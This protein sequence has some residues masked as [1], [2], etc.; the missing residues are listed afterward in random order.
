MAL[1]LGMVLVGATPATG[2]A[3][4]AA[5]PPPVRAVDDPQPDPGR[6]AYIGD[7]PHRSVATIGTHGALTPLLPPG[8]AGNDCQASARGDDMVWVSDR[9]GTG[10]GLFRRTGDGPVTP[11]VQL[12]GGRLADPVLSPDRRLIAFVS[13]E[14]DDG[15]GS[16]TSADRCDDS[17]G[18]FGG[19]QP[20]VWVVRTDGTGL[21]EA[22]RNAD[23]ADWSPDGT[24]FVFT[25][26]E[27]A[28]RTTVAAGGA[29]VPVSYGETPAAKPVWEP[30]VPGGRNRIAYITRTGEDEQ[31][32]ATVPAAG[33]GETPADI[34]AV[35]ERYQYGRHGAAWK[36]DG[37]EL[38]FLSGEP[39]LVDA[40]AEACGTCRGT[41]LFDPDD[42]VPYETENVGWFSP[43]GGEPAV[44][45]SG[46][47]PEDFNIESQRAAVPL[48]RLELRAAQGE[49]SALADPAYAPDGRRTAFVRTTGRPDAPDSERI[50]V[51]DELG[52]ARAVPLRYEGMDE[53]EHQERPAWSPD[54]TR[55]A[56]ARSA[57]PDPDVPD[58]AAEIVVVDISRGPQDGQL[59]H[60]VPKRTRPGYGC[61]SDDRDPTWSPDGGKL[62]FSR[63]SYCSRINAVPGEPL[64][65][66]APGGARIAVDDDSGGTADGGGPPLDDGPPSDDGAG[67]SDGPVRFRDDTRDRHIWTAEA[68]PGGVQFDV[69][70]AQCGS[71]DCAVVDLRPAYRPGTGSIAFVRQTSV[72]SEPGLRA[73][74]V[75]GYEGPRMV[76]EVGDDGT[77]CRGLVP[78]ANACPLAVPPDDGD[79]PGY[80]M[81]DNPAWSPDGHR[82]AVDVVVSG[83]DSVTDRRI[84]VVDP[85]NGEGETLPGKLHNGQQQPTWKPSSDLR[86][87]LTT[88]DS[89][90]M[91]GDRGTVV[92]V[93]WNHGV[94][95]SP[96]TR[97]RVE[98][99]TGLDF[100]AP[101]D[102]EG[103]CTTD[104]AGAR[105]LVCEVGVLTSGTKVRIELPVKGA[106]PG[107]QTIAA[108]AEGGLSDH[109]PEDNTDDLVVVVV[110]P[111]LAVTA[112][113]TPP[114]IKIREHSTVGFTVRNDGTATAGNVRLTLTVPPGLTLVSGTECPAA[115]CDLGSIAPG[116]EKKVTLVYTAE[117]AFS[118]TIEGRA[119]ATT[120]DINPDNDRASV[121]LTVVDP[122]M[123]DPAI[124]VTAAPSRIP[125]GD[126]S[127]VVYTVRNLGDA[128][129]KSV[130]LTPVLPS[131]LTVVTA[132]PACP[133]TGCALGDLAP[134]ARVTVTRVVTA[135]NALRGS[136]AGTLTTPGPDT[137]PGN[138]SASAPLTVDERPP[139]PRRSAD[140]SVS[141]TAGPRTAYSG[142]RITAE[143]SV[144]NG[145]PVTA[146]G[147]TLKVVV[148]P[149]L[150]IVSVSRP[151][152]PT[153]DGCG[154]G[155]LAPGARTTVRL[156][157]AA[158]GALTGA[159][160]A[161]VTTT[162]SDSNPANN[163]SSAPLTVRRPVLR[164]DPEL[165]PPGA[166][167]HA[168]GSSFP[169]GATVRLRWSEGV[170]AASAPLVVRADGTFSAPVLVLVQDALGPRE[171]R[172]THDAVPVPLFR[173]VKAEYLVVPG[174]L[175][176]SDFQWRR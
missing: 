115:G 55:L 161:A 53:G 110:V 22:V 88:R 116:A 82:L 167:T 34:L 36:P 16:R 15:E 170:T 32:L 101:S 129:A 123:P 3:V 52:L 156:Q 62:A 84:R 107:S 44:L 51:G 164:L 38:V 169:P 126:R 77:R 83:W 79:G 48:D 157:L 89:P 130:L 76:L 6:I 72:P 18:R 9:S 75:S 27:R 37:N 142:G 108:T 152:C 68:K 99:P 175:Q 12:D 17:R 85:A 122:R 127:T 97:V 40:G 153:A 120:R 146:T 173:E 131:G 150:R 151:P 119:T 33:R 112:T 31:A 90:L 106:A 13:W 154:L 80:D 67:T 47:D 73:A 56:F 139:P 87:H 81:P 94:A 30:A 41:P 144:R 26:D 143:V 145:G 149:G 54:G 64:K 61:Y 104:P 128:P 105:Q 4:T 57:P 49:E 63:W 42:V 118:G 74:P 166:V 71:P 96:R 59:L 174:A 50:L 58:P 147:L 20:S 35:G 124:S 1:L 21:R 159:I 132:T 86:V 14:N 28:Y 103:A 121:D 43:A 148:P 95:D 98:L 109:Q 11:V 136:V 158:D 137:N 70:A 140:P 29:E 176:P 7:G 125:A 172:A 45:V 66:P 160:T 133:A 78:F 168:R 114:V 8:A 46:K 60:V 10:E 19:A 93:V 5:E 24:E 2:P 65:G 162:G 111:D 135:N 117:N 91:L 165:G 100:V 23:W 138:N 141:V 155:S 163:T 39:Y 25:R 171:L 102:P 113:A 69:S 92:L 134:G